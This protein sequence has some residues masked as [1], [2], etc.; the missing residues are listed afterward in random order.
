LLKLRNNFLSISNKN[1]VISIEIKFNKSTYLKKYFIKG[2]LS[3]DALK[4]IA[5]AVAS[6]DLLNTI[7]YGSENSNILFNFTKRI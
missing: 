4:E 5:E 3:L 2:K 1:S 7:S 6:T